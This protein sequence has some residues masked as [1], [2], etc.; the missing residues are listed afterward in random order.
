MSDTMELARERIKPLMRKEAAGGMVQGVKRG[1]KKTLSYLDRILFG[2]GGKALDEVED[3]SDATKAVK[4][5]LGPT[6]SKTLGDEGSA[7]T[8]QGVSPGRKLQALGMGTG[9]TAAVGTPEYY[10]QMHNKE[11]REIRD[12]AKKD[13]LDPEGAI[14]FTEDE[15]K[16]AM[17]GNPR[18]ARSLDLLKMLKQHRG[19]TGEKDFSPGKSMLRGLGGAITG[20]PRYWAS[21]F[22]RTS[23]KDL[24]R[25][26]QNNPKAYNKL[27]L[28]VTSKG[29]DTMVPALKGLGTSALLTTS[30]EIGSAGLNLLEATTDVG[31]SAKKQSELLDVAKKMVGDSD[32]NLGDILENVESFTDKDAMGEFVRSGASE[33]T[34]G[35]KE[36]AQKEIGKIRDWVQAN[37]GLAVAGGAGTIGVF[38]A[39]KIWQERAK[40]KR[41]EEEALILAQAL[42]GSRR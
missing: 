21:Q 27:M 33:I 11:Q 31:S 24:A 22:K 41:K 40:R 1:G 20:N 34:T 6:K 36:G 15:W 14:K 7:W 26:K 32:K 30:P 25:L 2:K 13:Y 9:V 37:P 4:K 16:E 18:S 38:A 17:S 5:E 35:F 12:A 10:R 39:Y 23:V 19:Y 3:L 29:Q 28:K 8:H 42:K